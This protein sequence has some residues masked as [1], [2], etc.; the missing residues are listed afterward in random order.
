[1]EGAGQ[2]RLKDKRSHKGAQSALSVSVRTEDERRAARLAGSSHLG[3]PRQPLRDAGAAVSTAS[4]DSSD[5]LCGEPEPSRSKPLVCTSPQDTACAALPAMSGQG[6]RLYF[7]NLDPQARWPLLRSCTETCTQQQ[8]QPRLA[9]DPAR[10]REGGAQ[11]WPDVQRV[12]GK[13][14]GRVCVC[15]A[16]TRRQHT[17]PPSTALVCPRRLQRLAAMRVRR[18]RASPP[19]RPRRLPTLAATTRV[20]VCV[21]SAGLALVARSSVPA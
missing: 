18:R 8:P 2:G 14:P 5:A 3:T 19:H 4:D 17:A 9:G 1:M 10:G 16:S 12:G 13:K 20:C 15:G 21:W 6:Q 7:G 11:I